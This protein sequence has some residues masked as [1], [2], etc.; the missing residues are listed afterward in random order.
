M[1]TVPL[2]ELAAVIRSKNAGPYELTID[3][4]FKEDRHYSYLKNISFFT[5][6]LFARLYGVSTEKVI[7]L[8]WFDPASAV[9]CTLVR[10]MVSGTPGDADVYGAQQHAPVLSLQVPV[11]GV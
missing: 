8:V 6:E 5:K 3:I 9:K 7:N 1:K 11:E 10:P 4:L 2:T